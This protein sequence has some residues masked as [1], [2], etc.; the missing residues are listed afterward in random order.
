[1][2][3]QIIE[4]WIAAFL[5]KLILGK[6]ET[7]QSVA[8]YVAQ[9]GAGGVASMAAAPFPMDM[10]AP[11]FGASMAAAAAAFGT[12]GAAEG[13]DWNVREG[14]Y[15]LHE[16]E[17]VLPSWAASP[18]ARHDRKQPKPVVHG[19]RTPTRPR[20]LRAAVAVATAI[21]TIS[22]RSNHHD[23]SW[24]RMIQRDSRDARR[25]FKS[26]WRAGRLTPPER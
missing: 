21:S 10:T 26:E 3:A 11:A 15:H 5:I 25:W 16:N 24:D 13:G 23:A 8:N 19:W 7:G 6:Q 2:L 12:I 9:A 17:M 22:R 14:L 1:V 18:A 4:K 20:L